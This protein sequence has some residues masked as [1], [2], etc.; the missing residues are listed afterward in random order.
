[1]LVLKKI[2]SKVKKSKL[3]VKC[4]KSTSLCFFLNIDG[5]LLDSTQFELFAGAL[6]NN[7][8]I[9]KVILPDS[10]KSLSSF[11][12]D[13]ETVCTKQLPFSVDFDPYFIDVNT[14]VFC[15][16]PEYSSRITT[17][18]VSSLQSFVNRFN[19]KELT[20]KN[21]IFL[22]NQPLHCKLTDKYALEILNAIPSNSNLKRINLSNNDI[23]FKTLLGTFE[24]FSTHESPPF[25]EVYP[26]SIDF[27]LGTIS[28]VGTISNTDVDLLVDALNSKVPIKRVSF[29]GSGNDL[30]FSGLLNLFNILWDY[31]EIVDLDGVSNFVDTSIGLIRYQHTVSNQDLISIVNRHFSL[32]RVECFGLNDPSFDGIAALYQI[33]CINNSL[34]D[35]D[36]SHHLIDTEFGIFS[37]LPQVHTEITP[38]NVSALLSLEIIDLRINKCTFTDEALAVL[39]DLIKTSSKL[40]CLDLSY[41]SLSDEDFLSII[42]SLHLNSALYIKEIR[43]EGNSFGDES[44]KA[45]AELLKFNATISKIDLWGNSIGNEGALAFSKILSLNS[46]ISVII[47]G[48]NSMTKTCKGNLKKVPNGVIALHHK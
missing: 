20:L 31:K 21:C 9:Q 24:Q 18:E 48:N 16:S 3:Y 30:S 27:S 12:S 26:H 8:I 7:S 47:L 15:F 2:P 10:S 14:K 44:A 6:N 40:T 32:K 46:T 13:C 17:V 5:S 28:S 33:L 39:C 19:I 35:V 42:D 38:E 1:M 45:L 22:K 29:S 4:Y 23:G 37:F 43:F 11:V 36:I 34:I 41:C 25:I